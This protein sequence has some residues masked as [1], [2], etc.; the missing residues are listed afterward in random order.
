MDETVLIEVRHISMSDWIHVLLDEGWT[1]RS[2]NLI[3][4]GRRSWDLVIR[5]DW[6]LVPLFLVC[7]LVLSIISTVESLFKISTWFLIVYVMYKNGI[8]ALQADSA[9]YPTLVFWNVAVDDILQNI[10]I[11]SKTTLR[12][13]VQSYMIGYVQSN[14][15]TYSTMM[16]DA[17]YIHLRWSFL[18][19]TITICTLGPSCKF[20][21]IVVCPP[22]LTATK[23]LSLGKKFPLKVQILESY[24]LDL[25]SSHRCK[26]RRVQHNYRRRKQDLWAIFTLCLWV[27]WNRHIIGSI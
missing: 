5:W 10:P 4:E 1:I 17:C 27:N 23:H 26:R 13:L 24:I 12:L 14:P 19:K 7:P 15:P 2:K 6:R 9:F 11:I 20:Y 18:F 3:R 16:H 21:T 8:F 25:H 22:Q